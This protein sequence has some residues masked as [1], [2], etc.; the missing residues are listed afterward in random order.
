MGHEI[1]Y[2]CK[3][4]RGL[5]G[6]DFSTG[7]ALRIGDKICCAECA[8]EALGSA[9]QPDAPPAKSPPPSPRKSTSIKN[10]A[11]RTGTRPVPATTAKQVHS[12]V[13]RKPAPTPPPTAAPK[14]ARRPLLFIGIGAGA[15]ALIVV[16]IVVLM[17]GGGDSRVPAD[18]GSAPPA[19]P[20]PPADAGAP[21]PKP[22]PAV[23][24]V[25]EDLR[26]A[27]EFAKSNPN[28]LA[29]QV[30]LYT[31]ATVAA[32]GTPYSGEARKERAVVW[33]KLLLE[34]DKAIAVLKAQARPLEDKQDY[35]GAQAVWDEAEKTRTDGQ[36]VNAVGKEARALRDKVRIMFNDVRY[37][38]V[39][40][41]R[42][43]ASADVKA[44]REQVV[45]WGIN[46]YLTQFDKSVQEAGVAAV[47]P[48]P[49]PPPNPGTKPP[50]PAPPPPPTVAKPPPKPVDPASKEM[51]AYLAA[52]D[53]AVPL[54]TARD[55]ATA[56]SQLERAGRD[57]QDAEVRK[58][59]EG[60]V[61]LLKLAGAVHEEGLRILSATPR[62]TKLANV[63]VVDGP[64]DPRKISG[65]VV[66]ST[67]H[68]LEITK[69]GKE[70]KDRVTVFVEISDLGAVTRAEAFKGRGKPAETDGRAMAA[71][72]LLEGDI[73]SAVG[74]LG[75]PGDLIP[76]RYW[77]YAEATARQK[78]PLPDAREIEARRLFYDA[79]K[80]WRVPKTRGSAI[81]R[82]KLL[83]NEFAAAP[84][85][86]KNIAAILKRSQVGKEYA[87]FAPDLTG[88]GTFKLGVP[89][90]G[91]T[92]WISNKDIDPDADKDNY[93]R[94]D[95]HALPDTTYKC[96]A[97]VGGCCAETFFF[98]FQATEA[99][100]KEKGKTYQLEPG[101]NAS[102]EVDHKISGL[103]K[104][105]ASHVPKE[106]K[107]PADLK[108]P[109]RWEWAAIPIPAKFAS[110]GNKTVH[111]ISPRKGFAVATVIVSST[112]KAPP[113]EAEMKELDKARAAEAPEGGDD[114]D[115]VGYWKFDE[116]SGAVAEDCTGNGHAAK[117]VDSP[118]W[119]AG[120]AGGA[121]AFDGQNDRVEAADATDLKI[122]GD[123]TVA[124]WV[125]KTGESAEV[126]R[127]VGKGDTK[128][129]SFGV[130]E[131]A[132]DA[133]RLLFQQH[134]L[135]GA[136]VLN[137]YSKSG[138]DAGK[139]V[140][141]AVV[142]R[143]DDASIWING[144]LDA[145]GRRTGTPGVA[146]TAPLTFGHA[147]F[148]NGW[149]KGALDDI[150]LYARG[151]TGPEIEALAR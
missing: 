94:I 60:D 76:F 28:D 54:A 82:Y 65:W 116:P 77:Q 12:E 93:V 48:S 144:K 114:A 110:G 56:I 18:G 126:A 146:T 95:F 88:S 120:Q 57:A 14:A 96:W 68:R 31:A 135:A 148:G 97:L 23:A 84:I 106:T 139:W 30:E 111:L 118:A 27:R 121:L 78:L 69:E 150:R 52:W 136:P 1:V 17:S 102:L 103:K 98:R 35:R 108:E 71:L 73:N 51:E 130:W 4:Q 10:P 125:K 22:P 53:K 62:Y 16:V 151:L 63:E 80:E 89:A 2:C 9:P 105:H 91:G 140:H 127:L 36:W 128:V 86:A 58:A 44:L 147:G 34:I 131:E 143:G 107:N 21:P 50:P 64:G 113:S 70:A 15:V 55:Y 145:S 45:K 117:L 137:L 149:F 40:A 41:T 79:E 8:A 49:P 19:P 59:L 25:P 72:C 124:F 132:G 109:V 141:V 47:P 99:V 104:T 7:A 133:K 33:E 32:D 11:P 39:D 13:P 24:S 122:T 123:L 87:L 83:Q 75:G 134:N 29:R 129:R 20:P 92:A 81:E 119:G 26:K 74:L 90:R 3:C 101:S 112:R 66:H 142:M 67:P 38:A 5:R 100:F 115:L 42:R 138:L 43:G 85:V 46:D 37:R 6:A 61:A